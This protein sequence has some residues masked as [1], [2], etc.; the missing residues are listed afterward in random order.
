[1]HA[2]CKRTPAHILYHQ[3][4]DFDLKRY[5]APMLIIQ[6]ANVC[7]RHTALDLWPEPIV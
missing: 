7:W 4:R 3:S 5:P 1:M 2:K 6:N